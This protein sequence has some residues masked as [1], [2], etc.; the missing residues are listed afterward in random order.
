MPSPLE[1]RTAAGG[2]FSQAPAADPGPIKQASPEQNGAQ[3]TQGMV[4]RSYDA[5]SVPYSWLKQ[6]AV[7]ED[8]ILRREGQHDLKLANALLDD[9]IVFSAFQ[10]RQ[11]A[12]ISKDWEVEAGDDTPAAK[13]AA[14]HLRTQL[15]TIGW[16]RICFMMMYGRFYGY[17]VGELLFKVGPDGKI[18]IDE[19]V[20]PDRNWF[21]WTNEGELRMRSPN[22]P[23]GI[24]VPPNKFWAY[25]TGATH[26]FAP[27]GTGLFHYCYWPVWFKKNALK[28]WALYLEKFGQP[29]VVGLLPQGTDDN[30][31][32]VDQMLSIAQAVGRDS[33]VAVN[34]DPSGKSPLSVIEA[35]RG[36]SGSSSYLDF[37]GEMN[38]ELLRV[39]LGQTM[40]SKAASQGIGSNQSDTQ[41][42]VR[43]E[44]IAADSDMLHESF[45]RSVARWMTVW[46]FGEGVAAPRVYRKVQDEEDLNTVA[47]RDATLDG[48]GIKR[49][50]QSVKD[51][52]G[53]GYERVEPEPV[54]PVLP[55]LPGTNVVDLE[56]ERAKRQAQFAAEFSAMPDKPLII[57]RRLV[58]TP[59]VSAWIK[60]QGFAAPVSADD[61]RLVLFASATPVDWFK[62][63]SDWNEANTTIDGGP[64]RVEP[65]DGGQSV[66]LY[67]G[68]RSFVWRREA[69]L[70]YEDERID[71]VPHIVI[72]TDRGDV[73]L[74][75][76]EP[77]TDDLKFGPEIYETYATDGWVPDQ[78]DSAAFSA[79]DLEAID[80]LADALAAESVPEFAA[81]A[82]TLRDAA[83]GRGVTSA[84]ALKVALLE[85]AEKL[86]LDKLAAL[87]GLPM[88]AAR[89]AGAA[90]VDEGLRG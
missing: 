28:F 20:V 77:F 59:A 7:N 82:E 65:V 83:G 34:A 44:I 72:A 89:A 19:I 27:Y 58:N 66:A 67:F 56:A 74:S 70:G 53:D 86:P 1:Y 62:M 43:D 63:A 79:D 55:G 25:R 26:D 90:G 57:Y 81:M 10:Q 30:D 49:T 40:T 39:L 33:A 11:L 87:S 32:A 42:D 60:R 15:K 38:D 37:V 46:N 64:R 31:P 8:S 75:T 69:L 76:V 78:I 52:Y 16:D 6:L 51:V 73:D 45:N 50:E 88:L 85:A 47:T 24:A 35:T 18:W 80:R 21:A 17:A 41:K 84:D 29:T 9:P 48:I 71:W 2:R 12:L 23:D 36:G 61:L 3:P 13:E 5:F 22:D 68:A 4:S 14:D 54:V